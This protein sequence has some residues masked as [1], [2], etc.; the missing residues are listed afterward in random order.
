[1]KLTRRHFVATSA[2]I[3]GIAAAIPSLGAV[4]WSTGEQH[5][6]LKFPEGSVDCHM[7]LFDDH[8]PPV[9][10]AKLR[11]A[12][13]SLADY[14]QLQARLGIQR[15]VIVTPSTYGFNNQ[16]MMEGL[17][18]SGGAARG[19]AV[20]EPKI[21]DAALQEMHDAGVRGVRINLSFGGAGLEHL[22]H[23][24]A[25]VNELGW[26]VQFVSPGDA[27]PALEARFRKLPGTLVIDHLG[28]ITQ[29][30]GLNSEP[31]KVLQRLLDTDKVWVKLSG[32]YISTAVGA[33][34]Y[35]DFGQLAKLLVTQ[36]ADR[37]VWGSDWP[38]VTEK[39]AKPDDAILADLLLEWAPSETDRN[40]ILRDNPIRLYDFRT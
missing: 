19:V 29:P 18:D 23:L 9:P 6:R 16:V 37:L 3:I 17:R 14:R 22:E 30:G 36:R 25:R 35:E 28:E 21:N 1:M 33:P 5:P 39:G 13:A 11:P 38:H 4:P 8:V 34:G 31:F 7:H 2:S 40:R 12:G 32:A 26:H 24:S 15:M 20:I 27:L 10:N